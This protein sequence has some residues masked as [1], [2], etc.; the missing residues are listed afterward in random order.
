MVRIRVAVDIFD[1]PVGLARH[2]EG[3]V[4][5]LAQGAA[6]DP[7]LHGQQ[8]SAPGAGQLG[9]DRRGE[10]AG[11]GAVSVV[12]GRTPRSRLIR[13]WRRRSWTRG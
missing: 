4:D 2:D 13:P 11:L 10:S 7:V 5:A 8:F 12:M 3:D 9:S 6:E 1:D